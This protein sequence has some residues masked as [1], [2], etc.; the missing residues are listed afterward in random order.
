[1]SNSP[2]AAPAKT[3]RRIAGAALMA[4]GAFAL[5]GALVSTYARDVFVDSDEFSQ[6]TAEAFATPE[7]RA[8]ATD[9]IVS[10]LVIVNQ[11]LLLVRPLLESVVEAVLGS[12]IATDI[13]QAST[14]DL[15]R[16]LFSNDTDTVTLQLADLILVAKTQ[17]TVLDPEVGAMI[18]DELTDALIDVQTRLLVVD[19]AQAAEGL[20]FLAF[21]L[22]LLSI[23]A[24]SGAV[25]L[26]TTRR[27]AARRVGLL[28]SAT[29]VLVIIGERVARRVITSGHGS[30]SADAAARSVWDAFLT[31]LTAWALLVGAIGATLAFLAWFGI[32]GDN[33]TK[34]DSLKQTLR[35]SDSRWRELLGSLAIVGAGLILISYWS[36]SVRF[37][38]T[39]LGAAVVAH[40]LGR[41][42][43][44]LVPLVVQ[45][46]TAVKSSLP[47]DLRGRLL[48]AVGVVA[49]V[50]VLAGLL[51]GVW[52]SAGAGS[53]RR[54]DA[55]C[56]GNVLLCDRPFDTITLA[57]THNSHAAAA[58]GF[59]FG[60][61][62]VGI[63][64]QLEDGIR[65]F[66]IDVYF[67]LT[68]PT[69]TVVTDRAPLSSDE[70]EE[71]IDEVGEAAVRA[72]EA[73]VATTEF[74]GGDRDLFLCHAFCEI[75]AIPLVSELKKVRAFLDEN[76]GEV[77]AIVVQD[78]GPAPAD[79]AGAFAEAGLEELAYT[80]TPGPWPTLGEMIESESRIFVSAENQSGEFAWYHDAFTFIQDTP[81][82]FEASSE[83][84]CKLNRGS[85]DNP[86]LLVNHWL[87]PVS[88][89]SAAEVN[90]SDFLEARVEQCV[91]E[92]GLVP[93]MMAVDFHD[94]GD[95]V[96]TVKA[97]NLMNGG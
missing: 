21:A 39:L 50:M 49:A 70:R 36:Q 92:R 62:S 63:V 58:D 25:W 72:A 34:V 47:A 67:G 43:R 7:V 59:T 22:P 53:A 68:A 80:H 83:F 66:L 82:K 95:L 64:P 91:R 2:V 41:L 94:S 45:T 76:P 1:M 38:V 28:I 57:A 10:Q 51:V 5:V 61:Q 42:W 74:A 89:S 78:E 23:A 9:Q 73:I 16:S 87:S 19:A 37:F 11:D 60:Y 85:P 93:N 56:N 15:H 88:P 69:G 17:L 27:D 90:G 48:S 75:G 35:S 14:T 44:V 71:M 55:R 20:R 97:L 30:E 26:S 32:S 54:T 79:I 4:V 18:P 3:G 40:G 46:P 31:D 29:S 12:N 86:L 13:V 81:F 6:R 52:Q 96:A 8:V 33:T 24:F 65:G 84:T 77:I